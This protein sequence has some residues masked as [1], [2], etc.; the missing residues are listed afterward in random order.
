M[1]VEL[2]LGSIAFVTSVITAIFGLGGGMLLIAAMPGFIPAAAIIPLHSVVQLASN[3]SR[4]LF[5]IG[6]VRWEFA[7]AFT[8]GS[9]L[10]AGVAAQV[11]NSMNLDYL[12]L[13]IAGFILLNVWGPGL[14]FTGN[15]Q[16]EIFGIG[17]LQTG[18]GLLVGATGPLGQSTLLRKGLDRDAL[19][20]TTA[21][22]MCITHIFKLAV[23]GLI[24]FAFLPYWPLALAMI[25]G[26]VLGSWTGSRWRGH[27]SEKTFKAIL[28]IVLT[29]LALRIIVITLFF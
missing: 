12:P 15:L 10:G 1:A 2:I 26:S 8:L 13:F 29:V 9:V 18:I 25:T 23:F 27:F 22:F 11:V 24:G 28:K 17:A 7:L 16:S 21:L 5:G 14:R 4:A 20:V 3:G 6:S 19:V